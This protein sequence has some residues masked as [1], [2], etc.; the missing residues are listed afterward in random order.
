MEV[1]D[2]EGMRSLEV[3][4]GEGV[5]SLEAWVTDGRVGGPG[6]GAGAA[7]AGMGGADGLVAACEGGCLAP[8][9]AG[10]WVA[11]KANVQGF[12]DW[13][14]NRAPAGGHVCGTNILQGRKPGRGRGV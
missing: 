13:K 10:A 12:P 5:R 3:G 14:E 2:G 8:G 9:R 1:G 4:D 6:A 7:R 11:G